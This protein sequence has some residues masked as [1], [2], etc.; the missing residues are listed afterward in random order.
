MSNVRITLG[1]PK[2]FAVEARPYKL[3][4]YEAGGRR[5]VFRTTAKEAGMFG[6]LLVQFPS[7]FTGGDLVLRHGGDKPT[8][9]KFCTDSSWAVK[10]AAFY[11]DVKGKFWPI[12]SGHRLVVEYRLSCEDMT[13]RGTHFMNHFGPIYTELYRILNAW[14]TGVLPRDS[15]DSSSTSDGESLSLSDEV[16]SSCEDDTGS[17][18]DTPGSASDGDA[19]SDDDSDYSPGCG[20]LT[21]SARKKAAIPNTFVYLL[22]HEYRYD[23]LDLSFESLKG[24]D[25]AVANTLIAF[26]RYLQTHA[27]NRMIGSCLTEANVH[28]DVISIV[29]AYFGAGSRNG[30]Q[31]V[32]T[33]IVKTIREAV[34]EDGDLHAQPSDPLRT[35]TCGTFGCTHFGP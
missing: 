31:L 20:L 16:E 33:R 3:L 1:I 26:N 28:S 4:L 13:I 32:L 11:C 7:Q 34:V 23:G 2:N 27:P 5:E 9:V 17:G 21:A 14:E 19:S 6:T 15:D 24:N 18:D 29:S 35:T 22:E 30:F 25:R 8:G 10:Y 12:K